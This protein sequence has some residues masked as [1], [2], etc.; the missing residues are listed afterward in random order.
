MCLKKNNNYQSKILKVNI[1]LKDDVQNL[2]H[3]AYIVPYALR[4]Q[5]NQEL[6]RLGSEGIISIVKNA[7]WSSSMAIHI[8]K[9]NDKS[10]MCVDLKTTLSTYLKL[11]QHP[12]PTPEDTCNKFVGNNVCLTFGTDPSVFTDKG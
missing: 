9:Y 8:P 6:S 10:C 12:I 2:F 11:D 5:V 1:N 4:D 7:Y 3:K